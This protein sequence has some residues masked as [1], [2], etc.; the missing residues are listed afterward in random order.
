LNFLHGT[1]LTSS[2]KVP[3]G[4]YYATTIIGGCESNSI[5]ACN[6]T[7]ISFAPTV[8]NTTVADNNGFRN[9][10]RAVIL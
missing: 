6:G 5:Y 8:F 9:R 3:D 7:N 2:I 4:T 1:P 10:S